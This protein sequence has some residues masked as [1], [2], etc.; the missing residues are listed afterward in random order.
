MRLLFVGATQMAGEAGLQQAQHVAI[1][2]FHR[3]PFR[4][5]RQRLGGGNIHRAR[6]PHDAGR[7]DTADA[8]PR[9]GLRERFR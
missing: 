5:S 4:I 8:G 9:K 6:Q 1:T 7:H 2:V 3:Y